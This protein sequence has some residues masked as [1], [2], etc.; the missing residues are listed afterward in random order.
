MFITYLLMFLAYPKS[1]A[2][3]NMTLGVTVSIGVINL[4]KCNKDEGRSWFLWRGKVPKV[5][6][7]AE[8]E[9]T[10][11]IWGMFPTPK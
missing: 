3:S 2:N 5:G 11:P 1:I 4:L 9:P 6:G 8:G 7:G 10:P